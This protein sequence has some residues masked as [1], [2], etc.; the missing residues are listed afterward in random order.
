MR[1]SDYLKNSNASIGRRRVVHP[2][3]F[4][5]VV[6][7][8]CRLLL[9]RETDLRLWA[10]PGG[11]IRP[12]EHPADAAVRE[13]F[14]ETGL[15][16]KPTGLIGVF[17]GP[18]FFTKGANGEVRHYTAIAF[19]AVIVHHSENAMSEQTS[20]FGYFSQNEFLSLNM[21]AASKMIANATF[22]LCAGPISDSSGKN[23][24]R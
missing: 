5:S 2:A 15:L 14:E 4:V 22:A 21:P 7:E 12:R 10:L 24:G 19:K 9:R 11:G 18:E 6:D 16:I 20:E 8:D 13:C 3:V 17:G 1:I 23:I